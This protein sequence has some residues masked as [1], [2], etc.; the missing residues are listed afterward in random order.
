MTK[1]S[2][3]HTRRDHHLPSPSLDLGWCGRSRIKPRV[4][5][6]PVPIPAPAHPW[7]L[8]ERSGMMGAWTKNRIARVNSA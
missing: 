1:A 4:R 5:A 8:Q 6:L 2:G 3:L 7:E